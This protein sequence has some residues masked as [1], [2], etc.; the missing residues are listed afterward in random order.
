M[1]VD[2][3]LDW[4]AFGIWLAMLLNR[5]GDRVLRVKAILNVLGEA[6][7]VAVHGVQHI[8]HSPIHMRAWPDAEHRSRLVFIVDRLEPALIRRSLALFARAGQSH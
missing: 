2:E 7:P 1:T 4:T 5:H 6:N 8:V 3:P